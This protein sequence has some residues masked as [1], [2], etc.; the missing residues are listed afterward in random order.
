MY[1]G[2]EGV[3]FFV[4]GNVAEQIFAELNNSIYSCVFIISNFVRSDVKQKIEN[5]KCIN[6]N[7]L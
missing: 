5:I 4:A 2:I 3:T 6:G 7:C 1:I